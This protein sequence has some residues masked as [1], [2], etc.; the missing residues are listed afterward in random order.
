MRRLKVLISKLPRESAL[1]RE[2]SGRPGGDWSL[3][4]HLAASTLEQIAD[5]RWRYLRVHSVPAGTVVHFPD[6]AKVDPP[7]PL[8]RAGD[9]T[10]ET[11][12]PKPHPRDGLKKLLGQTGGSA[13][14]VEGG[15]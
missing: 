7:K 14:Y 5:L 12:A 15:G 3:A 8:R 4:E 11:P 1:S 9:N 6:A 2:M 10:V 13:R